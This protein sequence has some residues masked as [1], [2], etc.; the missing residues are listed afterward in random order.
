MLT[1]KRV[2]QT[3]AIV[4]LGIVSRLTSPGVAL[5]SE[6]GKCTFC[7]DT[8]EGAAEFCG[9]LVTWC[10]FG[11]TCGFEPCPGTH[12]YVVRC[13]YDSAN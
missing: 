6:A 5:A 13:G 1:R 9:E 12:N 4:V 10:F 2:V 8:C 7:V 11:Q 3:V